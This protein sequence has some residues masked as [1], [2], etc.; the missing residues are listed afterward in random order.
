MPRK[1]VHA[2]LTQELGGDWRTKFKEFN[3]M[4]FAAAS[5]GQVHSAIT[6]EGE[7]VLKKK[8]KCLKY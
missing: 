5:I 2:M 1:Q 3:E 4:P 7:E 8:E 6:L